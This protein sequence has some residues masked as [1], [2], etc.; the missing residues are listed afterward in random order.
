MHSV[1]TM[2]KAEQGSEAVCANLLTKKR[3][4]ELLMSLLIDIFC[5]QREVGTRP[6]EALGQ[7][8]GGDSSKI[9]PRMARADN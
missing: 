4:V 6:E 7:G 8:R 2:S 9:D 5:V 1:D 3:N